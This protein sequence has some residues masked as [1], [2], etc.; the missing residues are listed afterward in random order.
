MARENDPEYGETRLML[1]NEGKKILRFFSVLPHP[2]IKVT[3]KPQQTYNS[4]KMLKDSD[5]LAV[6]V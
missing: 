6:K 4:S 1:H 5:S 3:G 2:M